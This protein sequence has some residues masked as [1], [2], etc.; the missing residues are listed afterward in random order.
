MSSRPPASSQ[1]RVEQTDIQPVVLVI[2]DSA[3]ILR[4]L[5]VRLRNEDIDLITATNPIDGIRIAA[6]RQPALILLDLAM[7]VM[8]GFEALRLLKNDPRTVHI[9][10]IVVSGSD[11]TDDKVA[12]FNLGAIDYV[13]KPF[14]MPELRA[15][16]RSALRIHAL[17]R[18][19]SQ[20]A[21][22]DGLTELWN[23][24]HFDRRLSE[25]VATRVRTGK[26][27][28]LALCDL[29]NFKS[30]NDTHGHPA[31]DAVLITF[32][33]VL[34]SMLR[35]QDIAC[36]Y[37][38]EEFAL[39]LRDTT[40]EQARRLLDRI[41]EN[42]ES[43]RWP[44]HPER[45]ITASFGVCDNPAGDANEPAAWIES[46]DSALYDAKRAG[47][48]RVVVFTADHPPTTEYRRAG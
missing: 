4:L 48:N 5:E 1:T 17:M 19:L 44:K 2:D 47:R 3:E 32:A 45:T 37:G 38:G 16:M 9:P 24:A 26:P 34:M 43:L 42:L 18:M 14:N 36:R 28:T 33:K 7:P 35:K 6:E 29:D 30:L 23:R 27:F 8:D 40:A 22:I 11:D 25:E 20:R 13:C 31:G 12:G 10:V 15:R 41:R 39:I 21:Q 46:A